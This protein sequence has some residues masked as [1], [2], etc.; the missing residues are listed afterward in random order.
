LL[1]LL[2]A[3]R[4]DPAANCCLPPEPREPTQDPKP[5]C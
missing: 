2:K 5:C 3:L 1:T 4:D